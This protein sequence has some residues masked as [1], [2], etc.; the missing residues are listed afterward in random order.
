MPFAQ[1]QLR[2]P[3]TVE[4]SGRQVKRYHIAPAGTPVEERVQQAAYRL[5]PGLLPGPDDETP[6]A[7]FV[8]LHRGSDTGAYLCAYSWVWGNVVEC[9]TAAAGIPFLGCADHDPANFRPLDRP[10]IGCVWELAPLEH[11]RSAWVRHVLDPSE[12]DLEGYLADVL[13]EGLIGGPA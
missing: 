1:K 10:W 5:L 13:A 6:P 3:G 2:V 12:A 8:V 11:E 9:R 4:V 7:S